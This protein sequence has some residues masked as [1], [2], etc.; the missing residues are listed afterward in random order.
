MSILSTNGPASSRTF[1]KRGMEAT[2]MQLPSSQRANV[3]ELARRLDA[4]TSMG[5]YAA[6]DFLANLGLFLS[7]NTTNT[8]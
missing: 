2:L 5:Y 6:M 8:S 1:T 7:K 3:R 4:K